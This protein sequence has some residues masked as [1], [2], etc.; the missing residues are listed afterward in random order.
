MHPITPDAQKVIAAAGWMLIWWLTEAVDLA[1]AALLP[2]ILLPSLDILDIESA[3][4]PYGSSI[5]FL[6]MGGFMI[7]IALEKWQLHIRIAL[8]IVKMTGTNANGII[9]G[10]MASTAFMSMWISNTATTMM[11]LPIAGSMI[12]LLTKNTLPENK[13][14]VSNFSLNMMLG[15]AYAASIG[16][17]ATLIGTPPNAVFAGFMAKAFHYEVEFGTWMAVGLPFAVVLL[18][19]TYWILTFLLF[20]SSLQNFSGSTEIIDNEL[21]KIGRMSKGEKLTLVIF[22]IT[23]LLWIF[24]TYLNTFLPYAI[25]N[26]TSIAIFSSICLFVLPLDFNKGIFVLEWKDTQRLPWG[27]LLLFGG[28]LS[29]AEAFDKVGLIRLIGESVAGYANFGVYF[30]VFLLIVIAVFVTEVMSNVALVT[31]LVPVVAGIAVG[32]GENPLLLTIPVA[33]GASCA[34]MLP[35]ATPPNAVVFASGYV[36]ISQMAKAGFLINIVS[37]I[38]IY[39]VTYFLV[40]YVFNIVPGEMMEIIKP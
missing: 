9:F 12:N 35:M 10:F 19:L 20:P 37:V 7:A 27:I 26:D 11:M 32:L 3:S 15:I 16:G 40:P 29:L 36:K 23:A 18:L 30:V 13:R 17:I 8:N 28:G 25:L 31:V 6:F 33:I 39:L 38:L 1:V 4:T 21:S 34:F 5:V 2:L 14:K 24:R 22:T